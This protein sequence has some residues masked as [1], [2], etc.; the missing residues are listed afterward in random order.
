MCIRDRTKNNPFISRKDIIDNQVVILEYENNVRASFHTNLSSS[1]PERR[2]LICG[3]RGT[4]RGNL[5]NKK[6]EIGFID[7]KKKIFNLEKQIKGGHAG[8]DE[9]LVEELVKLIENKDYKGDNFDDAI[10][11]SISCIVADEA[12]KSNK[13]IYFNNIWKKLSY[14]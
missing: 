1:I 10:K 7:G 3:S 11:S 12:R 6:I 8:G 5:S 14:N 13:I 9:K 4:L 2:M